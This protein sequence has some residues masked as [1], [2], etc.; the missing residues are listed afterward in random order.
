MNTKPIR[1]EAAVLSVQKCV[2][3]SLSLFFLVNLALGL[4]CNKTL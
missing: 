4:V 2:H 1:V 3:T